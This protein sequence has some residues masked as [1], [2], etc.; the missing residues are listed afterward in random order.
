MATPMLDPELAKTPDQKVACVLLLDTSGSMQGERITELSNGL[1]TFKEEVLKDGVAA[2][3]VD[4]CVI[5]F[6][7]DVNVIKD[8]GPVEN[9]DV[10]ELQAE[11]QTFLGTALLEAVNRIEDRKETYKAMGIPYYRPWLFVISDGLPEG[12]EPEVLEEAKARLKKVQDR[13]GL[14]VY[15]IGIGGVNLE[16]LGEITGSKPMALSGMKFNEL[17]SWLSKSLEGVSRSKPGAQIKLPD[18]HWAQMQS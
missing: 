3:R 11:H 2:S 1:R 10:P 6:N 14:V 12:E 16:K 7:S 17:F 9:F 13:K 18:I 5:T 15:S 8:F 4:L